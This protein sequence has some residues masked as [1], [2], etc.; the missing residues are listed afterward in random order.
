MR[1]PL[2]GRYLPGLAVLAF[3]ALN[4][5]SDTPTRSDLAPLPVVN[6]TN[7]NNQADMLMIAP[8]G[9]VEGL[10]PLVAHRKA[11]GLSVA[12][13]PLDTISDAFPESPSL[14]EAIRASIAYAH[15]NWQEPALEYV[16]LVGGTDIIPTFV[17]DSPNAAYGE[18]QVSIDDPYATLEGND[19]DYPDLAL[20]RFPVSTPRE[21]T[22]V[23][24]KTL[25]FE[26]DTRD[27]YSKDMLLIADY[28]ENDPLLLFFEQEADNFEA[29]FPTDMEVTRM[30]LRPDSPNYATRDDLFDTLHAGTRILT[31]LGYGN[32]TQ[33]SNSSL[34]TVADP[35][36][37]LSPGKPSLVVAHTAFQQFDDQSGETLIRSLLLLP[38][39]GS[40]ASVA[41]SGLNSAYVGS[42][43]LTSFWE[44]LW[45][46]PEETVGEALLAAKRANLAGADGHFERAP[47]QFTLLGDPALR[48]GEGVGSV[49]N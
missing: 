8:S 33:W 32:A 29:Q 11:Q 2:I 14:G 17:F 39:G 37:F 23:I 13:L 15:D 42:I 49:S 46:R 5:C 20:G 35:P 7:A 18:D 48:L 44:A 9:L 22:A 36:Q 1:T 40:V 31:F 47:S 34:L 6:L 26:R 3:L 24:D 30:D 10:K 12:V 16:L 25:A 19:D 38:D 4:S 27:A 28:K 21:L 43:L 41:P 45:S